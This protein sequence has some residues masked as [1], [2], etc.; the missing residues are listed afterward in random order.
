MANEKIKVRA[1]LVIEPTYSHSGT[2]TGA[3]IARVAQKAPKKGRSVELALSLPTA[4]FKPLRLAVEV[5]ALDEGTEAEA[6]VVVPVA[7]RG[8]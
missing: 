6:C 5:Q 3:R 1:F 4:M 7:P 8:T 2:L